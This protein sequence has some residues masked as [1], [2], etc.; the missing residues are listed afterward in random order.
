M[1]NNWVEPPPGFHY[2]IPRHNTMG[3]MSDIGDN[4][5]EGGSHSAPFL[6]IDMSY[7]SFYRF[8]S[9]QIWY[10]KI[11]PE[12]NYDEN[13]DWT[14]NHEFITRFNQ[15]YMTSVER[16]RA[17]YGIPYENVIFCRD[18]PREYIWRLGVYPSYKSNRKT[19]CRFMNRKFQVGTVFRMI[20]Q[21]LIPELEARYRFHVLKVDE[22]EADDLVA[23]LTRC[24][25]TMDVKRWVFIITNDHDYL[26]LAGPRTQIWSLQNRLL[27]ERMR[28]DAEWELEYKIWSGDVSDSIPPCVDS[29]DIERLSQL[30]EHPEFRREFFTR[31]PNIHN[32]YKRNKTLIDFNEIPSA[33]QTRILMKATP[34]F[35][36]MQYHKQQYH[37]D[38]H[39]EDEYRYRNTGGGGNRGGY[40]NRQQNNMSYRR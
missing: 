11:H 27:N 12:S 7:V 6:L 38:Y 19:I 33:H 22:V 40:R 1:H 26:Q 31:H 32:I 3:N 36:Q 30:I 29:S 14:T 18:C 17:R 13:Y 9:T 37:Q 4:V 21:K 8:F 2:M 34:L 15:N 28:G 24:I 25:H 5:G 39:E 16:F 10:H 20:Y 35:L 23:V